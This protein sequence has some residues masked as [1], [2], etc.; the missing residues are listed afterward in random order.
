MYNELW[1]NEPTLCVTFPR[2]LCADIQA[3]DTLDEGFNTPT[4]PTTKT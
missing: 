2:H 1:E 3:F 4:A